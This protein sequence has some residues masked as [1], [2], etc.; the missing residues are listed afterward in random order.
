MKMPSNGS[1]IVAI[2]IN[3]EWSSATLLTR[4]ELGDNLY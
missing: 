2:A 3:K 1:F 4:S